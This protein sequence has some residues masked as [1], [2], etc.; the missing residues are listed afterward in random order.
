MPSAVFRSTT[1]PL[2]MLP[3]QSRS[4]CRASSGVD[5]GSNSKLDPGSWKNLALLLLR[6]LQVQV[7]AFPPAAAY[8]TVL[9]FTVRSTPLWVRLC[10][11]QVAQHHFGR[12]AFAV[13]LE[14][15]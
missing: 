9:T 3:M 6:A 12:F 13:L 8:Q 10:T 7:H 2:A 11:K 15:S 14:R 5:F 4:G 1:H